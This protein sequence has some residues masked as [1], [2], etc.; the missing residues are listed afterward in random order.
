MFNQSRTS[1]V[2]RATT[3]KIM[4]GKNYSTTTTNAI[5]KETN[6]I[7]AY[8]SALVT[9]HSFLT[10]ARQIIDYRFRTNELSNRSIDPLIEES[11]TAKTK[12]DR[13]TIV[14]KTRFIHIEFD[15]RWWGESFLAELP[16]VR[17]RIQCKYKLPRSQ[18]AKVKWFDFTIAVMNYEFVI[19]SSFEM[20][21]LGISLRRDEC[22]RT[23][24]SVKAA[25]NLLAQWMLWQYLFTIT[26]NTMHFIYM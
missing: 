3:N 4:N 5:S 25:I 18:C 17:K 10:H 19:I 13:I 7:V 11:R 6:N 26:L 14:Q 9:Q 12:I 24:Y 21:F 23:I 15:W 2:T 1:I 8:K 22:K 16:N 20:Q